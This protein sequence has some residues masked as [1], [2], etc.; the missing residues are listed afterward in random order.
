MS[1][2]IK[3]V[4]TVHAERIMDDVD[5]K[6]GDFTETISEKDVPP[7]QARSRFAKMFRN[8]GPK[9]GDLGAQ[10]LEQYTGERPELTAKLNNQ[11][12]TRIDAWL[13][14]VTCLIYLNQQLDKSS[15]AFAAVFGFREDAGMTN[16]SEYA[17]LTTIIYIAQLV[18]QP[19]K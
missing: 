15:V 1:D 18:F 19:R 4:S 2:E 7:A 5:R 6:G 8:N 16:S 11:V 10:W 9:D 17:W 3:P 13:L 12:K 14:P